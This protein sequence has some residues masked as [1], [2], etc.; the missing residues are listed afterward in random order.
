MQ[1][2]GDV[3]IELSDPGAVIRN[4]MAEYSGIYRSSIWYHLVVD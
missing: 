3:Y 4:N 2:T 1:Y